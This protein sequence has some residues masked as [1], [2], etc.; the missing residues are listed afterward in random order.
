MDSAARPG[1]VSDIIQWVTEAGLTGVEENALLT[2]FCVR[3]VAAGMP[4]SR[5]NVVIDTLHPV[6]E[7]RLFR[8]RGDG[9]SPGDMLELS[10]TV[11]DD[12][13][14]QAWYRSPFYHLQQSG[15]PMLRRRLVAN[16]PDDF[17][18]LPDL[19]EQ[20]QTDY[21][22]FVKQFTAAGAIGE[23]DCVHSSWT[24]EAVDGFADDDVE[25]LSAL[26]PSLALALKCTSL[27]RIAGTLV[28][29]YLGRDAGRRVLQGRIERGVAD[30]VRA[31]IWFSDLRGF[32]RITDSA[33][34]AH[35]IPFL[36]EYA[37]AVIS[38]IHEARGDVLK[39][40]GDGTLAIFNAE[41]AA[42]ACRNALAA[43]TIMG[44]RIGNLN[45]SR[46]SAGLPVTDAYLGLHLGDVFYGNIGSS[47]RLDFTVIGPA[48]NMASRV[49]MMCRSADRGM[50]MSSDFVAAVPGDSRDRIVSVGRY[51]LRGFERGQ[52]LFTVLDAT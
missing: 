23:M 13:I 12:E 29:T 20:G 19:R 14:R 33:E 27:Q 30:R 51:A 35:I 4:L 1:S 11:A 31:V 36:N 44:E 48:V 28:E 26:F 10:R 34:P 45:A 22:A 43:A 38:S 37:E 25:T 50:L 42:G 7:G 52:E 24:T 21:I 18:I 6:H 3:V 17:P 16:E 39:L 46:H 9:T 40:I 32:T 41:D 2:G 47:D 8:W 5:A 49:A 15:E